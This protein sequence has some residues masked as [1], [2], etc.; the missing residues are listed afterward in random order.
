MEAASSPGFLWKDR[1]VLSIAAAQP[2]EVGLKNSC[3]HFPVLMG[4]LCKP[5][6]KAPSTGGLSLIGG[7]ARSG[8]PVSSNPFSRVPSTRCSCKASAAQAKVATSAKTSAKTRKQDAPGAELDNFDFEEESRPVKVATFRVVGSWLEQLGDVQTSHHRCV[9]RRGAAKARSIMSLDPVVDREMSINGR[10]GCEGALSRGVALDNTAGSVKLLLSGTGRPS[11][12]GGACQNVGK[13]AER[14]AEGAGGRLRT[15]PAMG[16]SESSL[17]QNAVSRG[18]SDGATMDQDVAV[19][20][21]LGKGGAYE[22]LDSRE[23]SGERLESLGAWKQYAP[24]KGVGANA[25]R[26]GGPERG[27]E[28]GGAEFGVRGEEDPFM[29]GTEVAVLAGGS[30]EAGSAEGGIVAR[31]QGRR[32]RSE[33]GSVGG[34]SPRGVREEDSVSEREKGEAS[35]T[36]GPDRAGPSGGG[37]RGDSA[38]GSRGPSLEE[39]SERSASAAEASMTANSSQSGLG[40]PAGTPRR[41]GRPPKTSREAGFSRGT[42]AAASFQGGGQASL[43]RGAGA[44]ASIPGR[45]ETVLLG[46]VDG[47]DFGSGAGDRESGDGASTRK[48]PRPLFLGVGNEAELRGVPEGVSVL[49]ES[50]GTGAV[51]EDMFG[52]LTSEHGGNGSQEPV[53]TPKKRG[54]KPGTKKASLVPVDGFQQSRASDA[55]SGVRKE[56]QSLLDAAVESGARC[57]ETGAALR[58]QC[59]TE[60]VGAQ[61]NGAVS[62]SGEPNGSRPPADDGEL[63]EL[64]RELAQGGLRV[65]A[66]DARGGLSIPGERDPSLDSGTVTAEA[67]GMSHLQTQGP[68]VPTALRKERRMR[69]NLNSAVS[70]ADDP[71]KDHPLRQRG[72]QC[73]RCEQLKELADYTRT[74]ST[75]DGFNPFCRACHAAINAGRRGKILPQASLEGRVCSDCKRFRPALEFALKP[76]GLKL[77]CR[78]CDSL[79][80]AAYRERVGQRRLEISHQECG[81]CHETKPIGEFS[82]HKGLKTGH[83]TYCKKCQRVRYL[84]WKADRKPLSTPIVKEKKCARCEE[85]KPASEYARSVTN[86]DGLQTLCRGCVLLVRKEGGAVR[87]GLLGESDDGT[88]G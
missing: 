67:E 44:V 40:Q 69:T 35:A 37:K 84:A 24:R 77:R 28:H 59:N 3:Q 79:K 58:S 81:H 66:A 5:C 60:E 82:R 68:A 72:K 71:F 78:A 34:A 10:E 18:E 13:S 73:E 9:G 88:N 17:F 31:L 83:D 32:S 2:G 53:R 25:Q 86:F 26:K 70:K 20:G 1:R 63:W 85:T 76:D 46:K 54:R 62:G 42:E 33:G 11:M 7:C 57:I 41:R 47:A 43:T 4:S 61:N 19:S 87:E 38:E 50:E 21:A 64:R 8:G 23:Y 16:T 49:G 75:A 29:G 48:D 80:Q 51:V 56:Q 6:F 45:E 39:A 14:G 65:Q 74:V 52:V 55:A 30:T 15:A 36:R 22:G 27:A 12:I